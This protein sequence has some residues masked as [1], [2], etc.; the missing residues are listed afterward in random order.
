MPSRSPNSLG[1]LNQRIIQGEMDLRRSVVQRS[2]QNK[3]SDQV[4]QGFIQLAF[5]NHEG[6]RLHGLWTDFTAPWCSSGWESFPYT[7]NETDV[8]TYV[9]WPILPPCTAERAFIFIRGFICLLTSSQVWTGYVRSPRGSLFPGWTS[10][11]LS[12]SPHRASPPVLTS[13]ALHWSW[14]SWSLSFIEGPKTEQSIQMGSH[15]CWVEGD[16]RSLQC[17]G[18]IPMNTFRSAA[19]HLYS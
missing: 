18:C 14:S 5:E 3:R 19:N 6:C 10:P 8:W 4:A 9:H 7:L 13:L 16:S 2:V 11:I 12:A 15:A 17:P 1:N